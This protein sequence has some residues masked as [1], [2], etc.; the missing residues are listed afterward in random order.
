MSNDLKLEILIVAHLVCLMS[1]LLACMLLLDR[2]RGLYLKSLK[3][4]ASFTREKTQHDNS[5]DNRVQ[6]DKADD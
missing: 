5:F 2:T 3:K 6:K 4:S 1:A